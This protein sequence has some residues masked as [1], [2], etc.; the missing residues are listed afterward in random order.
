MPQSLGASV[1]EVAQP[2]NVFQ[3]VGIL[4]FCY[5]CKSLVMDGWQAG[6]PQPAS[7]LSSHF[8][9]M[10]AVLPVTK[11]WGLG[12]VAPFPT[13]PMYV[14]YRITRRWNPYLVHG[15]SSLP[16]LGSSDFIYEDIGAHGSCGPCIV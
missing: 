12:A 2:S 9:N 1:G 6:R 11:S 14:L 10:G 16:Q 7:Q 15:G 4:F 3:L 13:P 5:I 8:K